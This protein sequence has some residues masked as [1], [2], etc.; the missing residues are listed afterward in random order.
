MSGGEAGR[1]V[2]CAGDWSGQGESQGGVEESGLQF[3]SM[4][5]VGG[6]MSAGYIRWAK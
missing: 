1:K 3:G 5:C 2:D 4:L 6:D